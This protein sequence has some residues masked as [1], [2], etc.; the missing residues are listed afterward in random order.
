MYTCTYTVHV[1]T[2]G[3]LH[4]HLGLCDLHVHVHLYMAVRNQGSYHVYCIYM[5]VYALTNHPFS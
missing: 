4:V 2:L 3:D 5:Y 1:Y